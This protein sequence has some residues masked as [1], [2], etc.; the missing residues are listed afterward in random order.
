MKLA[1]RSLLK[2]MAFA[3]PA[4][5]LMSRGVAFAAGVVYKKADL[6]TEKK[7][8]SL[9]AFKYVDDAKTSKDRTADKGGVKAAEQT[10]SNCNFYKNPGTLEGGSEAVGQCLMLQS[11]VIKGAGWC[12]L[13]AKKA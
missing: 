13:W 3:A 7:N 9:A 8:P 1:R 4:V 6:A 5:A 10:C 11:Q 12:N 2:C